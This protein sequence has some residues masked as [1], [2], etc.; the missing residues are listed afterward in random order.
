M[1]ETQ[2]EFNKYNDDELNQEYE[3]HMRKKEHLKY[4]VQLDDI[5]GNGAHSPSNVSKFTKGTAKTDATKNPYNAIDST[6]KVA[7]EKL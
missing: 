1:T 3:E 7:K 2:K 4:P 6:I 5:P